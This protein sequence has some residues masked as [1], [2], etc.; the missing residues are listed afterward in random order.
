[1]S[2][3][4]A[5]IPQA[6]ASELLWRPNTGHALA[7]WGDERLV[8]VAQISR[9]RSH[10]V[11]R[12]IALSMLA[13][14]LACPLM[15]Q[16]VQRGKVRASRSNGEG[17]DGY[18]GSQV[19]G[20]CH[21][22]IYRTYM[23]TA[24]GRSM[25]TLTPAIMEK[26][27]LPASFDDPKLRRHYEVWAQDGSVFQSE[28]GREADG[29]E[30]FHEQHR[31]KWIVG[32]G[33]NVLG[34][35]VQR[36]DYLFEAPLALYVRTGDWGLAPGYEFADLGFS[37]PALAG[38]VYCH[39][40][41]SNPIAGS[42]G[43]FARPV[44][45]EIS[46][47]CE[48]CHGPGAS[49]FKRIIGGGDAQ[50]GKQPGMVNPARLKPVLADDIC[51]ACHEIGDERILQPGK[52][53]QDIRPGAPLDKV[54]SIFMT[55]PVRGDTKQVDHVQHYYS[56]TL[57]KCYRASGG[58]L[59]C[60]TC[61][62]PHLQPSEQEAPAYFRS[63]CLTCHTEKSCK[64]PL[65]ERL[66]KSND[67][68]IGCHMPKRK[69]GFIAHSSLTNHRI[70]AIPDEPLPDV[71]FAPASPATPG[72]I[73]LDPFPGRERA[74]P[75]SL[76]LLRA[77]GELAAYRPEYEPL[78][79]KLLDSLQTREPRNA[80]VLEALGHRS[81]LEGKPQEALRQLEKSLSIGPPSG[82]V[83]GDLGEA[84]TRLGQHARAVEMERKAIEL[85]PFNP[86]Y[87]RS[88]VLSLV[89]YK[90]FSEAKD[91]MDDYERIFPQD[92]F[93]RQKYADALSIASKR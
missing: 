53:Y 25:S 42:S 74:A 19:C 83:Y 67:D 32:S 81:L 33:A 5:A 75:P 44:F 55:P 82:V 13:A 23:Q 90:R 66:Q 73:H 36:E 4:D 12:R 18:T 46:I 61:H 45:P 72:L 56:M 65:E 24:M 34:G 64:L 35:L 10:S 57:S 40:G 54:L 2:R 37:R 87:R 86:V 28:S 58:K 20:E 93:M 3:P 27:H 6:H 89:G 9:D 69:I 22:D 47:G 21:A 41:R 85:E 84:F 77:Y 1:M 70:L 31:I 92:T 29:R 88:L 78:Y 91:A 51:M 62:D 30:I 76:T 50:N 11:G 38:C 60:I 48:N 49:H 39:S 63:K 15:V 8:Q 14:M 26:L 17:H 43:R 16:P 7:E 52:T 68:C 79:L 59:Q 80:F 71:A